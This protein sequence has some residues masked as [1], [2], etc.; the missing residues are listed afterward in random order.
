MSG[1]GDLFVVTT[2]SRLKGA[3]YFPFMFVASMRVRR[4]LKA[5]G[6]VV[7]WA[8]VVAGPTE[9]WTFTAW[10]SR[11]D[12][13]VF[14]SS[15]AHDDIMWLFA[16]WL[17]SFWLMRWRPA[18]EEVG[19]WRGTSLA[20]PPRAAGPVTRN[21]LLD[22]A[23]EGLPRLRAATGPDGAASYDTSPIA[24]RR[25]EEVGEA[26]GVIVH[27][28]VS[29]WQT[30]RALGELRRLA[31]ACRAGDGLLRIAAGVGRPG[32]VYL[33]GLWDSARGADDLLAGPHFSA[34]RGRW[35]EAVWAMRWQPENEFGHWDGLRVRRA[36]GRVSV[37]MTAEQA[38]LGEVAPA[39]AQRGPRWPRWRRAGG[40]LRRGARGLVTHPAGRSDRRPAKHRWNR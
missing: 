31:A 24:R 17:Q 40:R 14:A 16:R 27:L 20:V 34:L 23:L 11:H 19:S 8:S 12:M 18:S 2:R 3:R 7:A 37:R 25:R 1:A 21:P 28:D 30:F 15:G 13:A 29:P 32:E 35:G 33:L 6:D 36:R 4:Q 39:G 22:Q 10:R 5:T 26:A 9:F 38:A